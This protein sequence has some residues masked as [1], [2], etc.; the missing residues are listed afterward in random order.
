M[1]K[2]LILQA[3]P[4]LSAVIDAL[5]RAG[6]KEETNEVIKKLLELIKQL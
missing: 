5:N 6:K 3:I 1:D 4:S 2:Q